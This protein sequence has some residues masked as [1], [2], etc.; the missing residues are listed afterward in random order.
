[1]LLYMGDILIDAN[2]NVHIKEIKAQLKKKF[3]MKD[4]EQVKILG[5][6]IT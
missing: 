1:M 6:E 5:T 3:G 2:I 4:L